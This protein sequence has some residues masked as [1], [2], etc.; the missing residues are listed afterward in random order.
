MDNPRAPPRVTRPIISRSDL[1]IGAFGVLAAREV[2]GQWRVK[3][4]WYEVG[5][6][7]REDWYLSDPARVR[8]VQD[9]DPPAGPLATPAWAGSGAAASPCHA[10]SGW[11]V[12]TPGR[13]CEGR[14][15]KQVIMPGIG[16]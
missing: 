9:T 11:P 12:H 7:Q 13:K 3:L 14:M 15:C 2:S 16:G 1:A 10:A 8:L 4:L 6:S 5:V